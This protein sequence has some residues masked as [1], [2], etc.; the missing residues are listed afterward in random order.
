M[1]VVITNIFKV[2]SSYTRYDFKLIYYAFM[3]FDVVFI[4]DVK[5]LPNK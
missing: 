4:V 2:L 5:S 3:I 1:F